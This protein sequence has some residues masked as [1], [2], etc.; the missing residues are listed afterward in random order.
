[1][2]NENSVSHNYTH[3]SNHAQLQLCESKTFT[4]TDFASQSST[5]KSVP[6]FTDH[7]SVTLS[8]MSASSPSLKEQDPHGQ[9]KQADL[10]YDG[11]ASRI[12]F[13]TKRASMFR[14]MPI[15]N[16]MTNTRISQRLVSI[17]AAFWQR[18]IESL[19]F[20]EKLEIACS[21]FFG[22]MVHKEMKQIMRDTLHRMAGK[23][24]AAALRYF[25]KLGWLIRCLVRDGI[26]LHAM[27]QSLGQRHQQIGVKIAHFH[28]MLQ[29]IHETF[30]FY[31][32]T[33][34]NIDVQ[35]AMDTII[36]ETALIMTGQ[37]IQ[38][39][40]HFHGQQ[41]HFLQ[42]LEVCL[43]SSI[44]TEYFYRYL[45][46]CQCP[47]IR[48]YLE[49]LQK[50]KSQCSDKQRYVVAKQMIH[51]CVSENGVF[52]INI[53]YEARNKSATSFRELENHGMDGLA[54]S[55]DYFEEIEMEMRRLIIKNH[56]MPFVRSVQVLHN[57]A[58]VE[59][60]IVDFE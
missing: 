51:Q 38:R 36:H 39:M 57:S 25:D 44:G 56:W 60:L 42:S 11:P 17:A 54:V 31:F 3:T 48:H 6:S 10:T 35:Y 29:S 14:Q 47:E 20:D 4:T 30:S 16:R 12:S 27:L 40:N 23:P 45:Q 37:A 58:N 8:P 13:V 49:L 7:E 43:S 28:N 55:A 26:D 59:H 41:T 53:S 46:Q 32:P 22:L 18:H 15:N 52:A 33:E 50:F 9:I 21:C 24:E 5:K 1:M 34:Y 2:G 19:S